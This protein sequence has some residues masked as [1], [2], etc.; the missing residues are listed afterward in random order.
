MY[1]SGCYRAGAGAQVAVTDSVRLRAGGGPRSQSTGRHG[2]LGLR[3]HPLSHRGRGGGCKLCG[4]HDDAATVSRPRAP[5]ARARRPQ[6]R[7]RPTTP[8]PRTAG[9]PHGRPG[10]LLLKTR[11]GGC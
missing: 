11:P 1:V 10:H 3:P 9:D 6:A 2:G 5:A 7:P 4:R 8:G